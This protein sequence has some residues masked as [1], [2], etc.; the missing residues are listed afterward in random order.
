[1][2]L[3]SKRRRGTLEALHV[4]WQWRA[5]A[6][7]PI[8]FFDE[9]VWVPSKRNTQGREPLTLFDYQEEALETFLT[10]RFVVVLKARQ[11]GL[12]TIAMGYAL[13]H[14]LFSPGANVV[15][16][17]KNQTAANSALELLDFMWQFLPAWVK[18]RAPDLESDSATRHV[19]RFPDGMQS[20]I[21]SYAA[22]KTA[23]AGQTASLVLWDE[24]ALALEQE[25]T[26]R[27]L[28]PTTDAGGR[29][30][31]FST[32]RGA[33]N[34]FARTYRDAEKGESQFVPLFFPWTVSRLFSQADY[35][36]R[37]R[38]F[39][40]EPWRFYAEYPASAEEAFRQSGR[41]RFA[42]LPPVD[43]F[44]PF[45]WRG[46]IE[47]RAD[48]TVRLV[49][50]ETGPLRLRPQALAG[51]PHWAKCVV[52]VD[53]ATG[54]GGDFTAITLGWID[55]E[56]IP[57]RMGYWHDNLT[58]PTVVAHQGDALG[59]FFAGAEPFGAL[60]VVEKQ[61]GY[62]DSIIN[63]L[64]ANLGYG[65]LYVH[66]HTGHRKRKV[67]TSFGFPMHWTKRP[68]VIDKLAELLPR[69]DDDPFEVRIEGVDPL[70]RHELGAFVIREDG[71]VAADVGMHDDLVMSCAIWAFVLVEEVGAVT[72]EAV[73]EKP[74][75]QTYTVAHIFEEAEKARRVED[76]RRRREMRHL[77]RPRGASRW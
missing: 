58:E 54:Q 10:N 66:R 55:R 3:A 59:R 32:A 76:G 42:G 56:G 36:A 63:E 62:G 74:E 50:D 14:L 25:D 68:L 45:P 34:T 11:L 8:R 13:H 51:A 47:S 41:S 38:Q 46:R 77:V 16:V 67:E 49:E 40:S 9:C 4:E 44:E 73:G 22:T 1:M 5:Y 21:T 75:V 28:L 12:T 30:I 48:G 6:D 23:A 35:D 43:H 33:H 72:R 60:V 7:D 17:S 71:K 26:L 19:F 61:G 24:A 52:S 64:Q 69:E 53:P 31:V 27:T 70:L 29:M 15:L 57:Q 2:T 18:E 37:K 65:N 39:R 20:T